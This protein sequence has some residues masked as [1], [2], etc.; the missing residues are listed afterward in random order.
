[1]MHK[2]KGSANLKMMGNIATDLVMKKAMTDKMGQEIEKQ[3]RDALKGQN[4]QKM[5]HESDE[6]ID[7][8]F[9]MDS[10]EEE[11]MRKMKDKFG[12]EAAEKKK[13]MN[14]KNKQ[15]TLT[16]E[17]KEI[18]EKDFFEL[19]KNKKEK[20]I[21]NFSHDDFNRCKILENHMKKL[22][23]EHK[24][25]LFVKIDVTKSFFLV[26]NLKLKVLPT[27][28]F[29]E[30]GVARDRLTG[31]EELGNVDHFKTEV[32]ARRLCKYKAIELNENEKFTL[33]K[34]KQKRRVVGG[35]SDSEDDY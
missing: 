16:G 26:E 31:F 1:M 17:Y 29:F 35:E 32:L 6:D 21:A 24:E 19:I 23:Y 8:D 22:A 34:K 27:I 2:G 13:L 7:S 11:I 14:K 20:I 12:T 4:R 3:K 5:F 10:A 28:I 30:N 15:T 18:S 33:I 9:S 25:A